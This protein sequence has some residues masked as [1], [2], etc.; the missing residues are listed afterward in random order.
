[1]RHSN[2][3]FKSERGF[4]PLDEALLGVRHTPKYSEIA[5]IIRNNGGESGAKDSIYVAVSIGNI[6]AVK[7]HIAAGADV[8][9]APKTIKQQPIL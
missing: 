7:K 9:T 1:M 6:E 4:T 2:I 3:N 5:E 8:E